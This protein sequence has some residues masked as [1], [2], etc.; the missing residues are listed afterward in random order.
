VI[1]PP[2]LPVA[3]AIAALARRREAGP[4]SGTVARMPAKYVYIVYFVRH[5]VN[6]NDVNI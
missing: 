5:A 3:A 4:L 6:V 2:D 1:P